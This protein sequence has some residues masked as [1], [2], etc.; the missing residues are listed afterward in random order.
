MKKFL[1]LV[2]FVGIGAC[3]TPASAQRNPSVTATVISAQPNAWTE[4]VTSVPVDVCSVERVPVYDYVK[5]QGASG[6]EVLA[7]AL[8]GGLLGKAVTDEDEGAVVGGII[9]GVAAAEAGRASQLQIVGY[10]NKEICVT[11]YRENVESVVKNYQIRY[12]WNGYKGQAITDDQYFV[13][14]SVQ[15]RLSL[16][17]KR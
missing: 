3:A 6:L 5:G 2:A 16:T 15:V 1:A 9:G 11:R 12:E 8:F 13:G 17:L 14:D 4:V 10:Q 7:G